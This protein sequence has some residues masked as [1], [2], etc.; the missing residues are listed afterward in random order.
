MSDQMSDQMTRTTGPALRRHGICAALGAAACLML[1][2]GTVQAQRVDKPR[3]DSGRIAVEAVGGA[4]AGIGGYFIGRSA[5]MWVADAVGIESEG[6]RRNVGY[7]SGMTVAGLS[8]AGFVYGVG[9]IG[10]TAGDFDATLLG[11]GVGFA[12]ALGISHLIFPN[13][14]LPVGMSTGARWAT[15]NVLALLPSIG[16]TV[17]FNSTRRFQ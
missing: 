14:E 13:G 5:G 15:I 6:T 1:I 4:Y 8:T 3:L 9:S 16:A 12:A 2:A 11:T 17:G 10:D 7:V